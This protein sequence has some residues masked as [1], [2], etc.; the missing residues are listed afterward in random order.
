VLFR[1][2]LL[3][4]L[5]KEIN[6]PLI[7][8][9]LNLG[10]SVGIRL[11]KNKSEC[12]AA[13]EHAL[14]FANEILAEHAVTDIKEVNVSVIGDGNHAEASECEEPVHTAEILSYE[15]K[16]AGGLKS[17]T[18]GAKSGMVSL[19]RKIPAEITNET[20]DKIR[21]IA[22]DAFKA[23]NCSG[24]SRADFIIDLDTDKIY[25]NEINTIPG[26]LSFYL[27]E[28]LGVTY[29][30]LLERVIKLA[31]KRERENSSVNFS[32]NTNILKN[33]KLGGKGSK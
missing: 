9:P 6:F 2:E 30:E 15:D 7:I 33:A 13:I 21:R 8:K 12:A 18:N 31:L 14:L 20:R 27:W 11:A 4:K 28:P 24:V 16:Y 10:S 26:S 29:P 5:E 25:F 3:S 32:F 17:E 23:L 19:K 1:S 22:V